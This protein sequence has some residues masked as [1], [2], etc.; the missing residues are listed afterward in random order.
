FLG[1]PLEGLQQILEGTNFIAG[2]VDYSG[3]ISFKINQKCS[4]RAALM[5]YVALLGGEIE[6]SGNLINI[7]AHRGSSEFTEV[8]HEK[9]VSDISVTYDSRSNTSSYG[10]KLYKK[11]NFVTG[12]NVHILFQPFGIDIKTRIIAMSYNPFNRKEINIE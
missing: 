9:V 6:Y 11:I 1:D 7:R 3:S 2:H 5:Q 10:L 4:R 8:M 12:D